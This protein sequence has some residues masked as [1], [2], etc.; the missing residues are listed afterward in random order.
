MTLLLAFLAGVVTIL[1]PCVL[2]LLPAILASS[3][4]EGRLRPWGVVVGFVGCWSGA[5]LLLV[6]I[7]HA[8][9]S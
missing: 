2:P 6:A 5:T 8:G 3:G 7:V 4:Q 1:S 9:G